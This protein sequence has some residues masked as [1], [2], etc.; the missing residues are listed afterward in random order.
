MRGK[1][2]CEACR[3][4]IVTSIARFR[5]YAFATHKAVAKLSQ[6]D[7][8]PHVKLIID[9][10][11]NLTRLIQFA[12]SALAGTILNRSYSWTGDF[13]NGITDNHIPARKENYTYRSSRT[14]V[15]LASPKT[16]G[17]SPKARFAD[18][19]EKEL[20]A[21]LVPWPRRQKAR[22]CD[23]LASGVLFR[24]KS[25]RP[26]PLNRKACWRVSALLKQDRP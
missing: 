22:F 13:L 25:L 5:N 10:H 12:Y 24:L 2:W 17:H 26:S 14:V 8:T 6:G 11:R 7:A 15:I 20:A 9:H 18:Q 4:E 23:D 21:N 3:G 1:Q 19:M 16:L